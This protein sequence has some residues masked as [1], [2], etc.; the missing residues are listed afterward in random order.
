MKIYTS[1]PGIRPRRLALG[2]KAAHL[3]EEIGVTKQ[4]WFFW[5]NGDTMPSAGYLPALAELLQCSIEDLY[6]DG[7]EETDCHTSAAALVRNDRAEGSNA[8]GAD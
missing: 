6:R 3:A 2:R 1:L 8:D 5:E 4:A 7:G